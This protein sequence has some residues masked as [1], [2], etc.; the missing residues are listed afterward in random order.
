MAVTIGT[1]G[2][3]AQLRISLAVSAVSTTINVQGREDDLIGIA[4][5]ATQGA[6]GLFNM[7]RL[8]AL[9]SIGTDGG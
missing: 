8:S 9:G 2:V 5:S 7:P 1:T 4:D 6:V 3:S